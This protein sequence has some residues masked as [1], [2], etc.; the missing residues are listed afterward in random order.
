M[1]LMW[2]P[3]GRDKENTR[4]FIFS[5]RIYTTTSNYALSKG[6]AHSHQNEKL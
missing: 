4:G 5:A 3:D 6:K 2:N 1:E